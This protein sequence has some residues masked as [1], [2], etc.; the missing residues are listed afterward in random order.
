MQGPWKI[1]VAIGL[2]LGGCATRQ[3]PTSY[4]STS[5]ASEEATAAPPA[6]VGRYVREEPP[7]PGE[8]S[9]GWPG[10]DAQKVEGRHAH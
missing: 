2:L 7:L 4:P 10:L 9:D 6:T 5:A 1:T 3:R 8:P